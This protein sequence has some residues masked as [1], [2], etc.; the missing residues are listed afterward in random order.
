MMK[1]YFKLF[2]LLIGGFVISS[3][4]ASA[5]PSIVSVDKMGSD[6][7]YVT[8]NPNGETIAAYVVGRDCDKNK[9]NSFLTNNQTSYITVPNGTFCVWV[10]STSGEYSEPTKIYVTDSCNITYANNKTDTGK[11]ERCY[12][13]YYDGREAAEVSAEGA[14][15]AEGYSLSAGYS[16]ISENDCGNKHP[17]NAGLE[18]RYCKKVFAYKCVK[19]ESQ[20]SG[21]G[22][23]GGSG[24]SSSGGGSNTTVSGNAKLATLSISTGSLT[25]NFSSNTY[26]YAA[27][28]SEGSVTVSASLLNSSA[29]FI[30]GNG[31]RTVNLNYGNNTILIQA[32]DG[33]VT[34][35]YTINIKRADSRSSNNTLSSL[36]V[37]AGTLSP[38]FSAN[39]SKYE[40]EVGSDVSTVDISATLA[41]SSASFVDGFGPR[42]LAVSRGYT[43]AAIKV[44]SQSGSVRTYSIVVIQEG[45]SESNSDA[46]LLES[47]ELSAGTIDFDPYTFDYNVSVP[48]DVTN[49][50]VNAKPK[51]PGDKPNVTG[52]ENLEPDKLNEITIVVT[53]QDGS[54]S[55]TYTIYVTRKEQDL[56]ISDNSLLQDLSID[57]YKIKFDAKKKEYEISLKEEDKNKE[58]TINAKAA[59]EKAIVTI[60]GNEKLANG[61]KVKVRVT[62]EDGSYTDYFIDVKQAGR[63]GSV[64]LTI[65][66]IILIVVAMAYIVLRVMGYKIYFNLGGLK[67][68]IVNR[69]KK[70]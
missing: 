59:D 27:T 21:G 34:S 54:S 42:S 52:G 31:P 4:T 64:V 28:T 36:S 50:A 9:A 38:S 69:F 44:K 22:S 58:L 8:A 15:C 3:T 56:G 10:K 17:L 45:S 13:K 7:Y 29:T 33:G 48:Y 19:V 65:I 25:P 35:T 40:V 41:D 26:N 1:K 18:F 24:G 11:F 49:I 55:N 47:L 30:N 2:I 23:Q 66:V 61:S 53:S 5:A 14:S 51:T 16:T 63:G 68:K 39:T 67:D 62:A 12:R 46:A 70:N 60:E 57:G 37:S 43:R 20:P 6:L 32:Q